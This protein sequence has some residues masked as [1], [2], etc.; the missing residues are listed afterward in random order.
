MPRPWNICI[1]VCACACM[2]NIKAEC[3]YYENKKKKLIIFIHWKKVV[4][5]LRPEVVFVYRYAIRNA[6]ADVLLLKVIW[7]LQKN[8]ERWWP[9]IVVSS[10]WTYFAFHSTPDTKKTR[11]TKWFTLQAFTIKKINKN[12]ECLST[13]KWRREIGRNIESNVVHVRLFSPKYQIQ[14]WP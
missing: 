2:N 9:L 13:G 4:L 6:Y 5:D 7:Q 14:R 3:L 11:K 10:F 1:S 8:V 12:H